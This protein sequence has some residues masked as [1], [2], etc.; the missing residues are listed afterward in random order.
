[1]GIFSK[2]TIDYIVVGLG[3]PGAKYAETRHNAGFIS[4]DYIINKTNEKEK[5]KHDSLCVQT[6]FD[7]KKILFMK[8]QTFMN[9]SGRAVYSAAKYYNVPAENIIVI[10]DDIS[11]E[12]GQMR[13]RRSGSA[14]GHNGIKS[15]IEY[16]NSSDF[17]RIKVGVGAKPHADYDL[18]DWVL[19]KFPASD[20][21]KIDSLLP[22]VED[23]VKLI[24]NDKINDAMNKYNSKTAGLSD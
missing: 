4:I 11:L 22:W 3:N 19:S 13:I 24:V 6:R 2:S 8:P 9:D 1:M 17:P 12:P 16:L 10:F 7:G 23:A 20:R 15:I 5:I 21:K 18:A 14:G